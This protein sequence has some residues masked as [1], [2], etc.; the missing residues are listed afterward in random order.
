MTR[1]L[2]PLYVLAGMVAG[3]WGGSLAPSP[4]PAGRQSVK[5]PPKGEQV[6][7]RDLP[8][9]RSAVV[10]HGAEMG[11]L[12]PPAGA[13]EG[14]ILSDLDLIDARVTQLVRVRAACE[15]LVRRTDYAARQ[16]P[17][18]ERRRAQRGV[19]AAHLEARAALGEGEVCR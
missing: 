5:W 4:D 10:E 6:G 12:P 7:T 1:S 18:Y 3:L 9:H 14:G 8:G 16:R 13:Q 19:L 2:A 15:S 17:G 11:N